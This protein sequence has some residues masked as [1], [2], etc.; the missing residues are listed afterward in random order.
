[1]RSSAYFLHLTLI[2]LFISKVTLQVQLRETFSGFI[3]VSLFFFPPEAILNWECKEKLPWLFWISIPSC[4]TAL[5]LGLVLLRE[6][7]GVDHVSTDLKFIHCVSLSCMSVEIVQIY[8]PSFRI[9][10]GHFTSLKMLR[11]FPKE[12]ESSRDR[13]PE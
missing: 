11:C 9:S 8:I 6:Q 12:N 5:N 7:W 10:S 2:L 13:P 3:V 1:M 4:F